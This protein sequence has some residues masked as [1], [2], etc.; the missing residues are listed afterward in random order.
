VLVVELDLEHHN[1]IIAGEKAY[2]LLRLTD[3]TLIVVNDRCLHRGGPLHLG[4]WD[5]K[6]NCLVCP[7]HE[8]KYSEKILRK[9][10]VPML[11]SSG[12]LKAILDVAPEAKIILAKKV[13]FPEPC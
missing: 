8:T 13:I 2:F 7:W 6:L 12:R 5:A 11:R 1:Y 10:A 4:R 9:K 3:G